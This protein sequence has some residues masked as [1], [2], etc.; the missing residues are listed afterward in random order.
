MRKSF[1]YRQKGRP[2]VSDHELTE[3]L[4]EAIKISS[5]SIRI[6]LRRAFGGAN[7]K[8]A[9]DMLEGWQRQGFIVTEGGWKGKPKKVRFAESRKVP[10]PV[11]PKEVF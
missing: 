7:Y 3:R 4:T 8:R 10:Q 2:K 6:T 11:E 5:D 9:F 1:G